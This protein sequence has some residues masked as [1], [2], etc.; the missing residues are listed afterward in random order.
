MII[1][2]FLFI[3]FRIVQNQEIRSTVPSSDSPTTNPNEIILYESTPGRINLFKIARL[4]LDVCN[5]AMR[6]LM[7]SKIP[8]GELEL[9]KKIA[10]SKANLASSRLSKNQKLR[11]FP[12]NNGQ[13]Q[14]QSLD[15]TLM[16]ALVRNVFHEEIEPNS[17]KNNK[18]GK[19]PTA[20]EVGL[21]VAIES[22]RGCRNAFFGHPSMEV[23]KRTL[24]KLWN[25]IESA[26][27]EID[28][29]IDKSVTQKCYKK[30]VDKM[31]TDPIDSKLHSK[32]H[33]EL[34]FQIEEYENLLKMEG[35]GFSFF[36][37]I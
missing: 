16:Y 29:H 15:F 36:Q 4:L 37:S 31:K 3:S 1:T 32:L 5:D 8:G 23:D 10:S 20:G 19:R 30:E 34:G 26:V 27:D 28:K 24:N 17:K 7:Q 22:I 12:P 6:D 13:V 33:Q 21:V 9:T 2:I 18:W 11:L 25:T 14:Y 35:N